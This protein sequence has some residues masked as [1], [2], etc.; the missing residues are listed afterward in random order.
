MMRKRRPRL[1]AARR[2]FLT[3]SGKFFFEGVLCRAVTVGMK[4]TRHQL[5]PAMPVQQIVDRAVAGFVANGLFIGQLEILDVQQLPGT[6]G[7]GIAGQQG[8][9]LCDAHV[10]ALASAAWFWFERLDPTAVIGHVRTVHRAQRHAHHFRN[11]RLRHPTFAHQHHLDARAL[12]GW[13]FF[14]AKR[15]FQPTNLGFAALDHLLFPNQMITANHSLR[16]K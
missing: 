9:F 2:A 12:R 8:P 11:S 13:K 10:L 3:A 7:L 5:A 14:P 15:C 16:R 4:R 1:A 6:G